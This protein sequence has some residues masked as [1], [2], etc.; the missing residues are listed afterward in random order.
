MVKSKIV[1]V[2]GPARNTRTIVLVGGPARNTRTIVLV[3]GCFDILHYGYIHFLK[4]AKSL[5]NYLIVAIESDK[6]VKRLKGSGRPIHSQKQRKEILE[7]LKFV[8][9]VIILKD[10]M[11]DKDYFKLVGKIHPSIIAVTKGDSAFN[12]KK[13]QA[14]TV[15][16]KIIEIPKIKSPSTTQI[17]KLLKLDQYL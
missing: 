6:N 10:N 12:K 3:G 16:A 11:A 4:K 9:K 5:G 8:D 1:L 13:E 14:K 2:G 15:G 7:S 17:A